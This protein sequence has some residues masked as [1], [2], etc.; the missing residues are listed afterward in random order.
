M[1]VRRDEFGLENVPIFN[2]LFISKTMLQMALPP[3]VAEWGNITGESAWAGARPAGVLEPIRIDYV[4][5]GKRGP[6]TPADLTVRGALL[7]G[8]KALPALDHPAAGDSAMAA[9]TSK[10]PRRS[11]HL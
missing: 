10:K 9:P 1:Y 2:F 5:A 4:L 6:A 11:L 8:W 7:K 3:S